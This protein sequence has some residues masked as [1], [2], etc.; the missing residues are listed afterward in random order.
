[1]NVIEFDKNGNIYPYEVKSIDFEPFKHYFVHNFPL[2]STR[3]SIIDQFQNYIIEY[4]K[5]V[6]K[7]LWLWI[8]GS[9]VTQKENPNDIDFVNLIGDDI[10]TEK[11]EV[12]TEKFSS[13]NAEKYF[14]VDAYTLR[15]FPENHPKSLLTQQDMLYW[16]HWF[17]KTR[18]NRAKKRFSK[19]FIEF[20]IN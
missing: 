19:G 11:L 5:Q 6:Q 20:K 13:K 12:I 9:F 7:N 4:Q 18:M 2:N 10:Y 14:G 16:Y 15:V 17:T 8:D 1:M 3:Y